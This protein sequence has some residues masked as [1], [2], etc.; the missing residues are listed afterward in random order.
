[1]EPFFKPV[2]FQA[3]HLI[4]HGNKYRKQKHVAVPHE[5]PLYV[6]FRQR[7][8]FPQH[9]RQER[10]RYRKVVAVGLDKIVAGDRCRVNVVF[11]KR[12]QKIL[13]TTFFTKF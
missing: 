3:P 12:P 8:E 13:Q 10:Y 5:L 9:E 2:T 11:A 1:M 4:G 6:L 7:D